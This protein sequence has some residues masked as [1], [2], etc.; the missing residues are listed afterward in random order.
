M[1]L[2]EAATSDRK[3]GEP[4][5]PGVPWRDLQ[6][7]EPFLEMFQPSLVER[8]LRFSSYRLAIL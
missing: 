5:C 4:T 2:T 1:H 7:Y 6:F 3:S 8:N